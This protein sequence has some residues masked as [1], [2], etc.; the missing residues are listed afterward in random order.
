MKIVSG[1]SPS[2]SPK[3]SVTLTLTLTLT[4]ALTLTL[5]LTLGLTL[6]L[7]LGLALYSFQQNFNAVLVSFVKFFIFFI[8]F[9]NKAIGRESKD[10]AGPFSDMCGPLLIMAMMAMIGLNMMLQLI[11]MIAPILHAQKKVRRSVTV[12]VKGQG[13]GSG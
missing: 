5:I 7:N 11:P 4:L 2:F 1:I 6:T 10:V 8:T 12:R 13:E 9:L 3:L